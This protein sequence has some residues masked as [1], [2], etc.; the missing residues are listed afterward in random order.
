MHRRS[1]KGQSLV[2][3]MAGFLVFIP[4]AFLAVDV[5]GVTSA[6]QD[7]MNNSPRLSRELERAS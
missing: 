3:V 4:L 7:L 2:E 1:N 5:V 6:T